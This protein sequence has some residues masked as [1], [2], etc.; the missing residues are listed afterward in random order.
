M[1]NNPFEQYFLRIISRRPYTRKQLRDK[2]IRKGARPEETEEILEEYARYGYVD[3]LIYAKLYIDSHD[4]WGII[5]I[6][7]ELRARGVS[8]AVIDKA[9]EEEEPDELLRAEELVRSWSD[10]GISI[11]KILS[12]LLRRGFPMGVCREAMDRAC[13]HWF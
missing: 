3:D 5:R 10:C 12:R 13:G 7:A 1:K 8:S 6:R 11:E 4:G 2:L 9:L